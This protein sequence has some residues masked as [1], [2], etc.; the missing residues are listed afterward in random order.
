M[1]AMMQVASRYAL[2]WGVLLFAPS[3]AASRAYTSMLLAWSTTEVVRYSFFAWSL[4]TNGKHVPGWLLW[5]RYNTFFV[6]YP[7]GIS[8]EVYLMWRSLTMHRIPPPYDGMYEAIV[9][10]TLAIYPP[11]KFLWSQAVRSSTTIADPV[12]RQDH[13]FCTRT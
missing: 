11:G 4:A 12:M 3:V 7:I 13:T 10:S 5:L 6:L 9:W 8:S 2:V 1:T